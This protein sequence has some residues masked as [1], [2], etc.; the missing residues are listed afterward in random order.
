MARRAASRIQ[1][2]RFKVQLS[3][4]RRRRTPQGRRMG[5]AHPFPIPHSALPIPSLTPPSRPL[6]L[7]GFRY[8]R[9]LPH[10]AELG[11]QAA[12]ALDHAHEQGVIHRDIK[13]ANLMLDETGRLWVT[14][15]GLARLEA[16]AGM[17]MT[18]DL[19]GTLRYMSPN[20][21]WPSAWWSTTGPTFIPWASRCTNSW[22]C[23]RH[24]MA[25]T[26]SSSSNKSPSTN[27]RIAETQPPDSRRAGNDHR[28]SDPQKPG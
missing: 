16:D 26:G 18:G 5:S 6:H 15:F 23:G 22:P 14:D 2:S 12:E 10:V 13:P 8:P 3:R 27:R 7:P 20:R 21:P 4:Q 19:V 9:I 25:T 11:I 1:R 17:T 24:L 28:K